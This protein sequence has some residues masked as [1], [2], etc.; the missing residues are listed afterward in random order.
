[1]APVAEDAVHSSPGHPR[2]RGCCVPGTGSINAPTALEGGRV[3]P[4]F[5]S[6]SPRPGV[7][8]QPQGCAAPRPSAF[9]QLGQSPPGALTSVLCAAQGA[10][11]VLRSDGAGEAESSHLPLGASK[12]LRAERNTLAFWSSPLNVWGPSCF[13]M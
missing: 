12:W 9:S 11:Q 5:Q 2:F 4:I 3:L 1:M 7:Y 6:R 10:A 13:K 8:P